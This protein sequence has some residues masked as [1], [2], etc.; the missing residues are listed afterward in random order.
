MAIWFGQNVGGSWN[1]VAY[2]ENHGQAIDHY[3]R[4]LHDLAAARR[5]TWGEHVWPHDGGRRDAFLSGGQ[6]RSDVFVNL[7]FRAPLIMPRRR[8]PGEWIDPARLFL[9]GC[10]FDREGCKAGLTHLRKYRHRRDEA[11]GVFLNEPHHD[12]HSHAADAFQLAAVSRNRVSNK[13]AVWS[14]AV[15]NFGVEVP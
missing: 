10:R 2:Y 4:H 15:L 13:S 14:D 5:W 3:A 12:E 1:F 7:G 8:T 6:F 9:R 11:R